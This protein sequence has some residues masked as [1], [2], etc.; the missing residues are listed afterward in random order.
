MADERCILLDGTKGATRVATII[1]CV[2]MTLICG[3]VTLYLLLGSVASLFF[4]GL[5]PAT[6]LMLPMSAGWLW[7]TGFFALT[8]ARMYTRAA[9]SA[10]GVTLTRPFGKPREYTWSDFQQVCICLASSV[11]KGS[12]SPVLC[13]VCHGEKKNIYDRWKTDNPW[14]YRRLIVADYTEEI[15]EAVRSVC[16]MVITDL[17]GSIAYPD[18]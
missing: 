2:L 14:H 13:F 4:D 15:G 12:S 7:F 10:E 1:G 17:R 11:P 18:K 8:L 3:A 9:L 5:W 6:M 16:P